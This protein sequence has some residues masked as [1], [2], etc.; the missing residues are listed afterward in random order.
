[1]KIPNE[2]KAQLPAAL[3]LPLSEFLES[4][5]L[6]TYVVLMNANYVGTQRAWL[7]YW[8]R[9]EIYF[10]DKGEVRFFFGNMFFW[11][12]FEWVHVFEAA[13]KGADLPANLCSEL[14]LRGA[15]SLPKLIHLLNINKCSELTYE[16]F[17]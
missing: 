15:N 10:V 4:P 5:S 12:V 2:I 13:R 9:S 11:D 14:Y 7:N 1:M 8:L 3:S 17:N 16:R 6:S